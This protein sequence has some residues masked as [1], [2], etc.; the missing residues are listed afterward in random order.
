MIISPY[1]WKCLNRYQQ[2]SGTR[3]YQCRNCGSTFD[4]ESGAELEKQASRHYEE[5]PKC[6]A[7]ATFIKAVFPYYFVESEGRRRL[8]LDPPDLLEKR[9]PKLEQT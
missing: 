6:R 9:P 3:T 7:L 4:V 2:E 8:C 1:D 5:N